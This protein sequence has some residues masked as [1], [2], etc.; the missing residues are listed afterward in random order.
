M[1]E[2][3][4]RWPAVHRLDTATLFRLALERAPAGSRLHAVAE[5]GV[6]IRDVATV[7]GRRL[8]VPTVSVPSEGAA[9]HFGRQAFVIAVDNPTSSR[10]T[11]ERL[12][13]QP[14][15]RGLIADL[16]E[17]TYFGVGS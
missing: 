5:E 9:D 1:A 3:A 16:E 14:S 6:P 8:G 11:R 4:N 15:H 17:G 10:M 7:I 12:G 13:W 2:G